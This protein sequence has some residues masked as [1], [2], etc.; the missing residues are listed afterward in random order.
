MMKKTLIAL[1]IAIFSQPLFA[2]DL[3]ESWS[4]AQ[5]YD[6][7]FAAARAGLDA[8]REKI[9][10]GKALLLP[11]VSLAGNANREQSRYSPENRDSINSNGESYGYKLSLTQPIYR[12]DAFAGADQ[13]K[14][15]TEQAEVIFRV[16]EQD[17]ILRVA[18][19]YFEVLGAEEK[20]KQTTA[21]K[22]AV[23]QQLAQAKKS[24]EVGVS[25][26]TD[27]DEAQ[28]RF[29]SITSAEIAAKNDLAIKRNA[30]EQLTQLNPT[31]L[32][33]ISNRQQPTPPQP[34]DMAAW[35]QRSENGSLV[36]AGQQLGL[37][38]ASR[39]IDKYRLESSPTLDL[40]AGYGDAWQSAGISKSGGLDRSGSGQIGLQLSIPLFTG[41]DRSSKLREAIAKKE[42][43][44][45]TVEA[46]RR[47][48]TQF[49]KQAFLGVSSGAAQIL[50]LQQAL[51]SSES[52]LAS[53][54]LGRE[55]G[56]RTTIDVLNAEQAYFSTRYDLTVAR[57][58]YLYA[59]LQLAATSGELSEKD[60]NSINIWLG[61]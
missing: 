54:K 17:L 19:T 37:D 30:Y 10:Q 2:A 5:K 56:V 59:R 8:G 51:K 52:S 4:A 32:K 18:K 23:A 11:H 35:I 12:A 15:Q 20:V 28:A 7:N 36:I 43:Q 31:G 27:T 38:I 58:T 41:G 57:Y 25:T 33:P 49:T 3:I 50:A 29:D 13:L 34:N 48:T 55:V 22:E 46:S 60:L 26:I 40:V 14:K 6:A 16:A 42:Q 47:D 1:S 39:E 21:Q 9:E 44:R 61:N 45:Q 24:F 53:T